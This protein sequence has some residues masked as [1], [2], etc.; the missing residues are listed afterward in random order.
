MNKHHRKPIVSI[1]QSSKRSKTMRPKASTS[2][3]TV[4]VE[5][6]PTQLIRELQL[7]DPVRVIKDLEAEIASDLDKLIDIREP[8][9]F[10]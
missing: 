7:S 5:Q 8:V 3:T 9:F 1:E 10:L 4:A 6:E 2:A